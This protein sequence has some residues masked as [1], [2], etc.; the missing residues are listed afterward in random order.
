MECNQRDY[1]I[2]N[3][4]EQLWSKA[5]YSKGADDTVLQETI[6]EVERQYPTVKHFVIV[7]GDKDYRVK[8]SKLLESGKHVHVVSRA[9]ALGDPD[10]K[11]SYDYLANRYPTRFTLKRLE[12]LLD[13]EADGASADAGAKQQ[14]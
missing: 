12:D 13:Q 4:P 14:D 7:T 10:N 3:I 11:Y 8:V 1:R 9:T 5:R 2:Q 6:S